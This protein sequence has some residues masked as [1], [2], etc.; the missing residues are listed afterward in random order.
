MLI[1]PHLDTHVDN[2]AA[3]DERS[4]QELITALNAGGTS[5]FDVLYHRHRDWVVNLAFRFTGN[6]DTSLDILQETFLYF[7]RKFPGFKLTCQLRSFLY[8]V[9]R[10]LSIS[11]GRKSARYAGGDLIPDDVATEVSGPATPSS[12]DEDLAHVMSGLSEDH[13]EV[14]QMRFVDG[15]DLREISDALEIPV[16]TVKSRLHHALNH[17]RNSPRT[18]NYFKD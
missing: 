5:S 12:A 10:N 4:D 7:V 2:S 16:G 13:R 14:L 9:V 6:R 1:D 18:K 8:P 3:P 17:L 15:F 11:A